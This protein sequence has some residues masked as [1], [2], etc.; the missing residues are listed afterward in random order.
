MEIYFDYK[1]MLPPR[2]TV[3]TLGNFDGFHLGHQRIVGQTIDT[4]SKLGLSALVVTFHP[5]PRQLFS[6]DLAVVTPLDQKIAILAETGIDY[7]L[8]QPFTKDFASTDPGLFIQDVLHK[9]LCCRHVVIGYDYSFGKAGAG[10]TNFMK[11]TTQALGMGCDIVAPVTWDQEIIS[12]TAVRK[13][14]A[15]G[16]VETAAKY[17]GRLFSLRG[18]VESGAG[19]GKNLGFPTANLY[20]GRASA[21]PAFGVYLV[22]VRVQGKEFWGLANIGCHPTF[23]DNRISLEVFLLDYQGNLYGSI[24]EVAFFKK[25]RDEVRFSDPDSLKLQVR[26]DIDQALYL[27]RTIC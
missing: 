14:L 22:K 21:L 20:P 27:I 1:K 13:Y 15:M 26:Q 10:D 23:P 25:L 2:D 12:S 9:A 11:S 8:V 4:A 19:R 5:H 24:I 18:R 6:T 17:M 16:D 3:V 7:L